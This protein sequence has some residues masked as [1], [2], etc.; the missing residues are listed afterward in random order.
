MKIKDTR[1][2]DVEADQLVVLDIDGDSLCEEEIETILDADW[3]EVEG[4]SCIL[5][6]FEDALEMTETDPVDCGIRIT[7]DT[8]L[9]YV[10]TGLHRWDGGT[11]WYHV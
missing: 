7:Q 10:A 5:V 1:A 4:N 9:C 8:E 6:N 2:L 11:A 3:W